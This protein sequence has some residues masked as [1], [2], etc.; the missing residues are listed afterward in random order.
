MGWWSKEC[1]DFELKRESPLHS[2]Q[3]EKNFGDFDWNVEEILSKIL[4]KVNKIP[5]LKTVE[6]QD[7]YNDWERD[8]D[9]TT[10][11]TVTNKEK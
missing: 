3:K 10:P 9:W 2:K 7:V 6:L 8:T 4:E 5:T 1:E 11:S